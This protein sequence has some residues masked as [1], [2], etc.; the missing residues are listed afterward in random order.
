MEQT[1]NWPLDVE[2]LRAQKGRTGRKDGE[3]EIES[4][5]LGK[6]ARR[7]EDEHSNFLHHISRMSKGG[8]CCKKLD[9]CPQSAQCIM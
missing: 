7:F 3:E 5:D 8:S 2:S 4:I 1:G 6:V 9:Y